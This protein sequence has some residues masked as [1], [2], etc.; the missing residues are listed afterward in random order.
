MADGKIKSIDPNM[1]VRISTR[2]QPHRPLLAFA[3]QRP[4]LRGGVIIR[5][6]RDDRKGEKLQRFLTSIFFNS[7]FMYEK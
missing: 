4:N 2:M 6:N 7:D 1:E 5:A 3:P